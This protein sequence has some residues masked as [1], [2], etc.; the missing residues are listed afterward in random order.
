M[1][2]E[3]A[4]KRV[5][6]VV[7]TV[8]VAAAM[9]TWAQAKVPDEVA[10][11]LQKRCVSCHKGKTP[12]RGLSWERDRIAEA[13]DR[14][15]VERPDLM[16]IDTAAPEAS[17]LLKKVRRES[18]IEGKPM[19]PLKA[20][21]AVELELLQT[22]VLSLKKDSLPLSAAVSP[23]LGANGNRAQ[24][25]EA[26]PPAAEPP[27]DTPAFWGTHLINLPTT[28]TPAKGDVLFRVHHR[29]S[30]PVDSGFDNLL[31]LDSFANIL[32]GLGYGITDNLTVSI[33][34]VRVYKEFELSADWLI[35]EQGRTAGLPFSAALHG[36][37]S[38]VTEDEDA[39][40]FFAAVSLSRQLTR[41]LSVL[42]VPS[43][44][45]NANH[46]ALD[47]QSTFSLGLG[48]R[49]MIWEEFSIIAE[50]VPVLAG[51]N[52]I[53]SG[54]GLGIEK[55][56]GGHVFQVFVNNALGLTPAQSLPGGDLQIGDFDFRIGFNI[57]RTF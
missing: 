52:E 24:A 12:P 11:L 19:P 8:L 55:K 15:S 16:I 30:D 25:P 20:L 5:V 45:T 1:A 44:V 46:F 22:W 26:D 13:I 6:S 36:G 48:A 53:E 37:V 28:T 9:G 33:G 38:L 21:D 14:A 10:S 27:F 18:G 51:Y 7:L 3:S 39:V 31:G 43:F 50:W 35:A 56:I 57:F 2:K 17:Y 49:Y 29:F 40:K 34:R 41:R 32:L 54:W 42:V 4:M 47:P 23:G